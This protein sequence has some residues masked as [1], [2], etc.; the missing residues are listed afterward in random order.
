MQ[1][2]QSY[3][4]KNEVPYKVTI[5][6]LTGG[7]AP[8][9]GIATNLRTLKSEFWGGTLNGKG[10]LACGKRLCLTREFPTQTIDPEMSYFTTDGHSVTFA[11]LPTLTEGYHYGL[12]EKDGLHYPEIWDRYGISCSGNN[13]ISFDWD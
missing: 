4:G 11:N 10:Y 2:N 6:S 1:L 12:V 3:L 8:A 13:D 7:H 9:I 5:I